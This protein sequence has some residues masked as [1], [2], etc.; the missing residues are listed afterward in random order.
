MKCHVITAILLIATSLF[1][2]TI[3]HKQVFL[4]TCRLSRLSV[5][6][7]VGLVGELWKNGCL[8]LDAIWGGEWGRSRD[9]CIRWGE[10][11]RRG[12]GSFV[13]KCGHPIVTSGDFVA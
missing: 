3:E 6:R 9:W 2:N 13:G 7:S 10:D 4:Q 8:D 11:R 1:I 12:R 5:S